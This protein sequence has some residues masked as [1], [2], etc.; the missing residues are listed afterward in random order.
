MSGYINMLFAILM[1]VYVSTQKLLFDFSKALNINKMRTAVFLALFLLI[2][3]LSAKS[4]R[5]RKA[6]E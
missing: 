4:L 1:V 3:L 6:G 5:K 2:S